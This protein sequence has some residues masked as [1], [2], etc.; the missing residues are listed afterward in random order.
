MEFDP[1][2]WAKSQPESQ[3]W[4]NAPLARHC[5]FRIGGPAK[6]LAEAVGEAGLK[7]LWR[8]SRRLS[9][10]IFVLGAGTNV[11]FDDK[12]YDGLVLRLGQG[13]SETKINDGRLMAGAGATI[14][15][16]VKL[17]RDL[18]LSGLEPLAGLPG[19][20]GGALK[21]NAG[22]ALGSIGGLVE[23]IRILGPS[24]EIRDIG[25]AGFNFGYRRLTPG[26]GL[27]GGIIL[28]AELALVQATPAEV[29]KKTKEA[30]A[31][32]AGQPKGRTAGCVFKNPLVPPP[33]GEEILSAGQLIDMCGFKGRRLGGAMVSEAHANFIVNVKKAKSAD[34]LGLIEAIKLAV[35]ERFG[36]ALELEIVQP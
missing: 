14:A 22:G 19:T 24:G 27:K 12:G 10:P 30:L 20:L 3:V 34:V 7:A 33:G 32:R 4:P 6:L 9:W 28:G 5:S 1:E 25:P 23:K 17:A 16:L 11:L 35:F 18:G 36:L 26:P 29:D 13:H 31:L 15:Q 21:G 2:K 8:L